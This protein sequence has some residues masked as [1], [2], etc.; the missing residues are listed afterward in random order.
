MLSD[1]ISFSLILIVFDPIWYHLTLSILPWSYLITNLSDLSWYNILS[2]QMIWSYQILSDF[3]LCYLILSHLFW[4]WSDLILSGI[5]SCN[6]QHSSFRWLHIWTLTYLQNAAVKINQ[7]C[8]FFAIISEIDLMCKFP[9]VYD[10][11]LSYMISFDPNW[12]YLILPF[13]IL[14][15]VIFNP[16]WS[17]RKSFKSYLIS[18]LYSI[19]ILC[20][21]FM[22]SDLIS[23]SESDIGFDIIWSYRVLLDHIWVFSCQRCIPILISP[24]IDKGR[25]RRKRFSKIWVKDDFWTDNPY[26]CSRVKQY[27]ACSL[28]LLQEQHRR[29]SYGISTQYYLQGILRLLK[30]VRGP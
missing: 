27:L 11:I 20:L 17:Y 4:V 3:L 10:P 23:S 2:F 13:V 29:N 9:I 28:M 26:I 6:P 18:V 30:I 1:H 5:I 7:I 14:L 19:F 25:F 16:I 24:F 8:F 22:L 15:I 21:Y 12:S